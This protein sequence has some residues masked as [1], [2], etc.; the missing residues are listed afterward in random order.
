MQKCLEE[1]DKINENEE[2]IDNNKLEQIINMINYIIS[3]SEKG[4][5]TY[6]KSHS[7]I[8]KEYI[9]S[10]PL[11]LN[12]ENSSNEFEELSNEKKYLFYGNTK[13]SELRK[14]IHEKFDNCASDI[15]IELKIENSAETI[16]LNSNFDNHTL[17]SIR[18]EFKSEKIIFTGKIIESSPFEMRKVG[19]YFARNTIININQINDN[20]DGTATANI[21]VDAPNLKE[22]LIERF[23][24][25]TSEK[26]YNNTYDQVL[27]HIEN[28]LIWDFYFSKNRTK[29]EI[30]IDLV[31]NNDKWQIVR[32]DEYNTVVTGDAIAAYRELMKVIYEEDLA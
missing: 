6:I 23:K 22:L 2:Y 21:T 10:I 12:N 11:I 16:E 13:L 1:I 20:G 31:K 17:I 24:Q 7:D 3:E 14:I 19:E 8:L 5:F 4:R 18:N 29:T 28:Q 9:I 25:G 26:Y 15:K 30:Q 27:E 32:N